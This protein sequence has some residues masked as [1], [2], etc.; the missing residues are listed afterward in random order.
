M[1][2]IEVMVRYFYSVFLERVRNMA[3]LEFETQLSWQ[4]TGN[5]GN[6]TVQLG[7]KEVIYSAPASMGGKGIGTS[8]EELL[9]AAVAACYSGTYMALLV[10]KNLPVKHV[11][12]RVHGI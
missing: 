1:C 8:P 3:D 5:D 10:R 12:I 4:A 7:K 2:C 11:D 9:M 6:G